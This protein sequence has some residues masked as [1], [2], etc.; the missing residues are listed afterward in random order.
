MFIDSVANPCQE[1]ISC[2]N[3]TTQLGNINNCILFLFHGDTSKSTILDIES[4]CFPG[5]VHTMLTNIA[6]FKEAQC[7]QMIPPKRPELLLKTGEK[8]FAYSFSFSG[9]EAHY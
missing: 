7:T 1:V 8:M 3:A 5:L 6:V 4:G 2:V 9:L